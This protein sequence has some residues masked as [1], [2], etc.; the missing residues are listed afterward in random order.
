MPTMRL[1]AMAVSKLK[2]PT[3]GRDEYFD[4]LLTGLHL[5][6][7]TKNKRTWNLTYRHAG[8][9]RRMMLGVYPILS[10]ADARDKARDALKMLER[11][12]D[13][14]E[15]KKQD[16]L[17]RQQ[18]TISNVIEVFI[19]R[20]AK[21]KNRTWKESR[22]CLRN[23]V[24]KKWGDR[25]LKDIQRKEVHAYLDE[26]LDEG[27]TNSANAIFR[28]FRKMCNW[29]AERG[30]IEDSPCRYIQLPYKIEYRDRIMSED[31]I[32]LFWQGCNEIGYPFGDILKVLMLTAQR[33]SEV[34]KM[35]WSELDLDAGLWKI[36]GERCKNGRE[37]VVP[38]SPMAVK[39][40][41]NVPCYE[42]QPYVFSTQG[43]TTPFQGFDKMKNLL[44]EKT[45][46]ENWRIH[47]IRRSAATHISG[48]GFPRFVVEK[49]LNHVDRSVTGIYDRHNYVK[50]KREALEKWAEHLQHL[51][52]VR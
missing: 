19:E 37:N 29:S 10:L 6:I 35:E 12:N 13:P 46:L 40:L 30:I 49:L 7:T 15:V 24:G 39:I 26:L 14:A 21:P 3:T 8:K 17:E 52:T 47:D 43:G 16:K 42:P 11:G 4:E 50:E 31:E 33:R 36:P 18:N 34:A 45:G 2:A 9:S 27:R 41:R 51:L 28:A 20:H 38:L 32:K 44:V 22:N 1:T 5:R 25:P 48:L 23:S